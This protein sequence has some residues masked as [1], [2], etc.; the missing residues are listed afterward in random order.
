MNKNMCCTWS[1]M[2]PLNQY[3]VLICIIYNI[4][5]REK[6]KEFLMYAHD[7]NFLNKT[8]IYISKFNNIAYD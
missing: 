6:Y 5:I 2:I 1:V 3:K 7:A 4:N 8:A